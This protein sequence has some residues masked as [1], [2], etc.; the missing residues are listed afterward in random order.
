VENSLTPCARHNG[1]AI[2]SRFI[3]GEYLNDQF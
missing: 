2:V 3:P 1:Q